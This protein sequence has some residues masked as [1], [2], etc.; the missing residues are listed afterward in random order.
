MRLLSGY[1]PVIVRLLCGNSAVIVRLL[2]GVVPIR[3]RRFQEPCRR[4]ILEGVFEVEQGK[5]EGKEQDLRAKEK[6]ICIYEKNVVIL[7]LSQ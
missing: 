6:N 2:C 5:E 7:Q 4:G 3:Y 1:C